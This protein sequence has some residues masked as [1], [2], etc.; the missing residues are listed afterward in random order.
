LEDFLEDDVKQM[1]VLAMELE[2]QWKKRRPRS[3]VGRLC[4]PW[5]WDKQTL[6]GV[7]PTFVILH[8]MI[9]EDETCFDLEFFFDNVCTRLKPAR[10]PDQSKHFLRHGMTL[11]TSAPTIR[12]SL[13]SFNTIGRGMI[14][15]VSLLFILFYIHSCVI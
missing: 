3:K 6:N 7:M 13:I 8:N 11:R 4:I 1:V 15:I 12:F 2:D 5:L 14:N 10:N 9:I